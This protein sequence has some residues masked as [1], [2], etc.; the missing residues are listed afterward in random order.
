MLCEGARRLPPVVSDL[1]GRAGAQPP[2]LTGFTLIRLRFWFSKPIPSAVWTCVSSSITLIKKTLKNPFDSYHPTI[3]Y[4]CLIR[5][6]FECC[7]PTSS[8]IAYCLPLVQVQCYSCPD[9]NAYVHFPIF[10]KNFFPLCLALV[11][12]LSLPDDSITV[13]AA[14]PSSFAHMT[15][16]RYHIR[17]IT[18]FPSMAFFPFLLLCYFPLGHLRLFLGMLSQQ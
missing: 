7:E 17:R 18:G 5:H 10:L 11:F 1:V 15:H 12:S 6:S 4:S 2:G 16:T 8:F 3:A 14:P 13:K 9:I